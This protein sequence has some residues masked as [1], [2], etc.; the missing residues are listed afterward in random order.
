MSEL[1]F[2]QKLLKEVNNP[3]QFVAMVNTWMEDPANTTSNVATDI[4]QFLE[5][6]M[7]EQR[8]PCSQVNY[9][10]L[11]DALKLWMMQASVEQRCS[12]MFNSDHMV[13]L[14]CIERNDDVG[15]FK[16]IPLHRIFLPNPQ[17]SEILMGF[18]EN[19]LTATPE[20]ENTLS[21]IFSSPEFASIVAGGNTCRM[22]ERQVSVPP[23]SME[24]LLWRVF[25]PIHDGEAGRNIARIVQDII[26]NNLHSVSVHGVLDVLS[27]HARQAAVSTEFLTDPRFV[28]WSGKNECLSQYLEH[29]NTI[30]PAELIP[31]FPPPSFE[32]AACHCTYL[33]IHADKVSLQNDLHGILSTH[34]DPVATVR[35]TIEKL[36][37]QA[38]SSLTVFPDRDIEVLLECLSDEDIQK[39]RANSWDQ[40]QKFSIDQYPRFLKHTLLDGIEDVGVDPVCK[41]RVL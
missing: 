21:Y 16:S 11:F 15:F 12:M 29:N 32:V 31:H 13:G 4:D 37:T 26:L 20:F 2:F 40:D 27:A 28:N 38:N 39:W 25:V 5:Q 17:R 6:L 30:F 35:R 9:D 18:V 8:E 14:S 10:Q 41:K 1:S 3:A 22:G 33:F 36:E 24:R 19:M 34:E 7:D 23:Q